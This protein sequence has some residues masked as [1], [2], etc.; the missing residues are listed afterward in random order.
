V[1]RGE[2]EMQDD[3]S[4]CHGCRRAIDICEAAVVS[5]IPDDSDVRRSKAPGRSTFG[6]G[7]LPDDG[8]DT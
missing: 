1:S 4:R 6:T 8:V 5:G 3:E 2:G 7:L